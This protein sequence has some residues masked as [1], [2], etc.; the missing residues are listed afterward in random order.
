MSALLL[1][2]E[3]KKRTLDGSNDLRG[4]RYETDE[5]LCRSHSPI[6]LRSAIGH[7]SRSAANM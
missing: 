5:G 3:K 6:N 1:E 7:G 2:V 4:N